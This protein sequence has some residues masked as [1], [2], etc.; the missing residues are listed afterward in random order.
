[1]TKD[2]IYQA[3]IAELEET[4]AEIRW[5]IEGY[6][7]VKDGAQGRGASGHRPSPMTTHLVQCPRDETG[8]EGREGWEGGQSREAA[9]P[10][11]RSA[12]G[13]AP[14][15]LLFGESSRA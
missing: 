4:L 9:A 15:L 5:M 12:R 7:D 1:M 13:S 10:A 11:E 8:G 2:E 3:R 6:V 14:I